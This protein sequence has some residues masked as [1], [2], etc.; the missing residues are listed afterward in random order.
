MNADGSLYVALAQQS[1]V[2]YAI[3]HLPEYRKPDYERR[4]AV[5]NG[6][7][8]HRISSI[9]NVSEMAKKVIDDFQGIRIWSI[10]KKY[11]SERNR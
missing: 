2:H 3:E 5:L 9:V 10:K 4:N 7:I 8:L 1:E 11:D 6:I